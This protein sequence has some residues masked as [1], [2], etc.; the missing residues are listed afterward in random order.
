VEERRFSAASS[1][2]LGK[3]TTSDVPTTCMQEIPAGAKNAARI[4]VE[5]RRFSAASSEA[6][7]KGTTSV[8]PN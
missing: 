2:A 4:A 3:G 6:L 7:G 8:V 5:E 1:E